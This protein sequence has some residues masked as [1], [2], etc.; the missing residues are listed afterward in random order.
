MVNRRLLPFVL[1]SLLVDVAQ[2]ATFSAHVDRKS[3]TQDETLILELML[4]DSDTRLRAEGEQ[5]NV[6]LTL[7]SQEFELGMPREH[8]RF[9]IERNR[10][11]TT[12][13]LHVELFPRH[14]G[15]LT[16]PTFTVGGLSTQAIAV[17]VVKADPEHLRELFVRTGVIKDRLWVH[18]TTLLY[19]DLYHRV[20]IE[21]AQLGGL[22]DTEPKNIDL[23]RIGTRDRT[24]TVN[25][26][27]YEVNRTAWGMAP[28][29]AGTIKVH[30]PDVWIVTRSGKK[31]RLPFSDFTISAK[32]LPADIPT[33]IVVGQPELVIETPDRPAKSD[34]PIPVKLTI[35]ANTL[36]QLLPVTAPMLDIPEGIRPYQEAPR[37]EGPAFDGD[38]RIITSVT[39]PMQLLPARAGH[40]QLPAITLPYFDVDTGH[41][42]IASIA[43][44]TLDVAAQPEETR[45]SLVSTTS[46]AGNDHHQTNRKDDVLTWQ[47]TSLGLA[48]LWIGTLLII[49]LRRRRAPTP[50]PS[51]P[52][53]SDSGDPGARLLAAMGTRTLEAGLARWETRFGIDPK[54]RAVVHAVQQARYAGG[55]P[56][57]EQSLHRI[58]DEILAAMPKGPLTEDQPPRD[59][60]RPE[61]FVPTDRTQ[62]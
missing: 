47:L 32:A 4:A 54:R 53:A 16:I 12:S 41:L 25:G 39:Y 45:T 6:D 26:L 40:F 29:Q 43:G 51:Q 44:P 10:G 3:M 36:P 21:S 5:P 20:D 14:T 50:L 27:E 60:W 46:V 30:M 8:H 2:G 23:E 55:D 34:A 58:V 31:R 49:R 37:V 18:E 48:V 15:N 24:E 42:V 35:R 22:P 19:L 38:D 61:H 9:N 56:G 59:P 13:T 1:L 11:R 62:T 28:R 52:P 17:R 57:E 7:L 33:G